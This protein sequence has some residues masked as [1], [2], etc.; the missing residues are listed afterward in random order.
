MLG[1]G[2]AAATGVAHTE[3]HSN[4]IGAFDALN[5]VSVSWADG[6]HGQLRG[7]DSG[8]GDQGPNMVANM[9]HSLGSG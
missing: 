9:R 4:H 6:V 7:W 5:S 2:G 1:P 8:G 3:G